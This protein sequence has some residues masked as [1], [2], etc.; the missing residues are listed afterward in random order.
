M[1]ALPLSA[2]ESHSLDVRKKAIVER[3][4]L[5][6]LELLSHTAVLAFTL[7][8]IWLIHLM[9]RYF[10]GKDAKFFDFIPISW[11]ID[12]ADVLV[13]GKFLRA[14]IKDFKNE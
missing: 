9:L 12:V 6:I 11:I 5:K 3:T 7:F 14:L 10:F 4:A 1:S 13:I 8:S 2:S